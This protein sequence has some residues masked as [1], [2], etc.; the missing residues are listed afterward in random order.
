MYSMAIIMVEVLTHEAPFNDLL[1]Y[2]EV[3]DVLEA[4]SGERKITA[5][6]PQAWPRA[7]SSA[8]LRPTIPEDCDPAFRRVSSW[9]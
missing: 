2:L 9:K 1:D 6:L 3:T 5:Q 7:N 8:Y 4:V